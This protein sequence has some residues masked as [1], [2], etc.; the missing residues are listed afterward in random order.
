MQYV[1]ATYAVRRDRLARRASAIER[2]CRAR[3][4][5]YPDI[6]AGPAGG[7]DWLRRA[8][9]RAPSRP[10]GPARLLARSRACGAG[11]L[12]CW[13]SRAAQW[14]RRRRRRWRGSRA[15]PRVRACV[16]TLHRRLGLRPRDQGARCVP[17]A[18]IGWATQDAARPARGDGPARGSRACRF[19]EHPTAPP[20]TTHQ[21]PSRAL[22]PALH[23]QVPGVVS[24]PTSTSVP[25]PPP[26]TYLLTSGS[27]GCA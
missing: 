1:T 26:P 17:T 22:V 5:A 12:L 27:R 10:L 11:L 4:E 14:R 13:Q 24:V 23:A 7:R 3:R 6:R 21:P 8:G 20:P 19:P 9:E 25:V 2:G 18:G 15:P 16:C